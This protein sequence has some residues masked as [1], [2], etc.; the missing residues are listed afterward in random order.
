[1]KLLAVDVENYGVFVNRRLEFEAGFQIVYGANETG[2]TTLL[3]LIRELL[4]GFPHRSR[5]AFSG[6]SGE[7]AA[8][9]TVEMSGGERIRFRRRKG[10]VDTVAGE[11]EGRGQTIDENMLTAMLGRAE[12][13]LYQNVFGFSVDELAAGEE[14]LRHANFREALLGGGMGNLAGL[15]RLLGSLDRDTKELFGPRSTK[16]P[17]NQLLTRIETGEEQLAELAVAP[18]EYAR[19]HQDADACDAR[20]EQLEARL[21]QLRT[22]LHRADLKLAASGPCRQLADARR[23]LKDLNRQLAAAEN[24]PANALDRIRALH[25]A[26]A[27]VAARTTELQRDLAEVN[28]K[29]NDIVVDDAFV[30]D[31]ELVARLARDVGRIERCRRD[32]PKLRQESTTLA[33]EAAEQLRKIHPEW[34]AKN[35]PLMALGVE[36]R[37]QLDALVRRRLDLSKESSKFESE[38]AIYNQRLSEWKGREAELS[39]TGD[40]VAEEQ[41][42]ERAAETLR[43]VVEQSGLWSRQAEL[44][45]ELSLLENRLRRDW[46]LPCSQYRALNPDEQKVAGQIEELKSSALRRDQLRRDLA[47][48]RKAHEK[49][50]KEIGQLDREHAEAKPDALRLAREA[51]DQ[52]LQ[53]VV[54]YFES[55]ESTGA[56][57]AEAAAQAAA[58][59]SAIQRA[60][61]VAELRARNSTAVAQRRQLGAESDRLANELAVLARQSDDEQTAA[62]ELEKNWKSQWPPD[63]DPLEYEVAQVWL[64]DWRQWREVD[65]ALRAVNEQVAALTAASAEHIAWVESQRP[66][67]ISTSE[68]AEDEPGSTAQ[69]AFPSRVARLR[70]LADGQLEQLRQRRIKLQV[71]A[72]EVVVAR[73]KIDNSTALQRDFTVGERQWDGQWRALLK[74]L[75]VPDHWDVPLV[76]KAIASVG[77][78]AQRFQKARELS[79]RA[80][81]VDREIVQYEA[82]SEPLRKHAADLTGE[83]AEV[84]VAQL[85]RKLEQ[86]RADR[87]TSKLLGERREQL[88]AE[89]EKTGRAKTELDEERAGLCAAAGVAEPERLNDVAETLERKIECEQCVLK[90]E[91]ELAAM[92][93]SV[94]A[95]DRRELLAEL[96]KVEIDSLQL[97]RESVHEELQRADDAFQAELKQAGALRDRLRQLELEDRTLTLRAEIEGERAQLTRAIDRWAPL[98]LAQ[99]VLTREMDRFERENQPEMLTAIEQTFRRMTG[100]R[101]E[102]MRQPLDGAWQV[103]DANG[104]WKSPDQLSTG[105]REQ[106]YLAIRLAYLRNY[107][108]REEVL[109]IVMDDVL[110][111][112][113]DQRARATLEVLLEEGG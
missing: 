28:L 20:V 31:G 30:E 49:V 68:E 84:V 60:D 71:A 92:T 3:N 14:S 74:E 54:A 9:A 66:P 4:F 43:S 42:W 46:N 102:Q 69:T 34:S 47:R 48:V 87:Q 88:T 52:L 79:E 12:R 111:N 63:V 78:A 2:K 112:F 17:I 11:V 105:A 98:A 19:W 37:D 8:T 15:Q 7:M 18:N 67:A 72:K 86:T 21:R 62:A 96:D 64:R 56:A 40:A 81:S 93:A 29:L 109:P 22:R 44:S 91:R 83:V 6:H 97:E 5:Y 57:R 101:Y 36:H 85:L 75:G 24:L 53:Q 55:P 110:V 90:S 70:D 33:N 27:S 25:D 61:E 108:R 100:G 39:V 23:M 65:A 76:E 32:L 94:S 89:L 80:E 16:P 13:G 104:Q 103:R 41:S 58:L 45:S 35:S 113:D 82:E 99:A 106:L 95:D 73:G 38:L 1:M 51:R 50:S 77:E 59:A 107:S 10:R 26:L